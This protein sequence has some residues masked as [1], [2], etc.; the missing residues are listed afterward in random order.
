MTTYARNVNGTAVDVTETDPAEIFHPELAEAFVVVPDGTEN[1]ATFSGG[2][3]TNPAVSTPEPLVGALPM[4]TPMTLYMAF[5]P[6]E[7]I[8][9]KASQDPMVQEFWAMYQLSVQL[10]K[11]TDPN[12]VSVR[13]AIAYLASPVDP[14]PGA[15]ILEGPERVDEI[16]AGIPQ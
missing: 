5:K 8:A 16:L 6:A 11:P 3:W 13:M 10:D 14:G 12:L 2:K 15:G 9:I 4:L 1:G 7:R